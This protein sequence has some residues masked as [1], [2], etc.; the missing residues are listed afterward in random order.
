M[1]LAVWSYGSGMHEAINCVDK[2]RGHHLVTSEDKLIFW[3]HETAS[4]NLQWIGHFV[5]LSLAIRWEGASPASVP[6]PT[7]SWEFALAFLVAA[8]VWGITIGTRTSWA[9]LLFNTGVLSSWCQSR[10]QNSI[11]QRP[12]L[13]FW[14]LVSLLTSLGFM[15]WAKR[16]DGSMPTFDDLRGQYQH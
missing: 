9:A 12:F 10:S 16:Y 13:Q 3:F 14:A 2:H 11:S 4:H 8:S 5:M 6:G 7:L 1:A 15:F